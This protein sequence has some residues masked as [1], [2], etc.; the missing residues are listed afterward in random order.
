MTAKPETIIISSAGRRL[1]L[2]DWFREAFAALDIEGRV[3]VAENDPTS[4]S[5]S[6]GDVGR[7]LPKYDDPD[8][9]RE[10]MSLVAEFDAKILI[11]ANDYELIHVHVNS[12]LANSLRE[13]GVL[14]PGVSAAW[15]AGCADK[16][17]MA[18]MLA[19]IEVPTPATVSGADDQG[20]DELSAR[21]DE[22][23]V[24]HRFGSGSSGLRVVSAD[25]VRQAV[26]EAALSAPAAG[27]HP[28]TRD[29]VVVQSKLPGAEYGVDIIGSLTDGGML[30]GVLARRKVRMRAGE[31]DKAVT[32][33]AAP[34]ARISEL[35]AGAS[36]LTGLIDVDV[37]VDD[38][39]EASVIDINP[40]FGGGY[41]FVH[42]AGADVPLYYLSQA[43]DIE[44]DECWNKYELGVVSAKYESIRVTGQV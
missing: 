18:Q 40:R 29:D 24:K 32:V 26:T 42:L 7:S 17:Q 6:Y 35:I 20:I 21:A 5:A 37:F 43:F 30:S 34:F 31:T 10:L 12:G 23:V 8:Y 16:L 15:Q 33:D 41:P 25:Q 1:Y 36:D 3:V 13:T 14:V 4:S 39:G 28:G 44:V 11:S 19:A 22:F 27:G 38:F 2:I 9:G